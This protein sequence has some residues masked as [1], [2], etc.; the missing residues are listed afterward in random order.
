MK[1]Y[2]LNWKG[3]FRWF[4]KKSFV[5]FNQP[6]AELPGIYLFTFRHKNGCLIYSA[7]RTNKS[8]NSRLFDHAKN[9]LCGVYNVLDPKKAE[10]GKRVLRWKWM[11]Y[12]G[13]DPKR[14]KRHNDFWENYLK[15]AKYVH[16][17]LQA[18]RVFTAPLRADRRVLA[19]IEGAIMNILYRRRDTV[20]ALPDPGMALSPR[21][22]S[23]TMFIV[24]SAGKV[25]FHGLPRSFEA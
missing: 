3:P 22:P 2:C 11:G 14:W 7:G 25:R 9:Y 8:F 16:A 21:R 19:R 1:G 17:Q 13:Y 12:G 10:A 18:M 20:G 4:G 23:E 6:E 15:N 5:V 24:K